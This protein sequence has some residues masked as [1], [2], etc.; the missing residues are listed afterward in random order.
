MGAIGTF[1]RGHAHDAGAADEAVEG[2]DRAEMATPA[3]ARDQQ[4]EQEHGRDDDPTRAEPEDQAALEQA[5]GVDEF[6]GDRAGGTI[7]NT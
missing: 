4:V 2:A 6:P 3:A 1:G 7:S 5:D